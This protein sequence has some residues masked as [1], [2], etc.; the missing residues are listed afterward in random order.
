MGHL[1]FQGVLFAAL[2]A[3]VAQATDF[4]DWL[5]RR[6]WRAWDGTRVAD[7]TG[8]TFTAW[9]ASPSELRAELAAAVLAKALGVPSAP[10]FPALGSFVGKTLVP[11]DATIPLG[12]VVPMLVRPEVAASAIDRDSLSS[13]RLAELAVGLL[14]RYVVAPRG[15][16]TLTGPSPTFVEANG[17]VIPAR[18]VDAFLGD[19]RPPAEI[20]ATVFVAFPRAAFPSDWHGR[21]RIFRAL[22][23][24]LSRLEKLDAAAWEAIAGRAF[25][26]LGDDSRRC[27]AVGARVRAARSQLHAFFAKSAPLEATSLL[28][29]SSVDVPIVRLPPSLENL[30]AETPALDVLW[31]VWLDRKAP[32]GGK[33][34]ANVQIESDKDMSRIYGVLPH[35][36]PLFLDRKADRVPQVTL[37][38]GNADTLVV[39]PL[40]DP[41]AELIAA[42][43][44]E[45]GARVLALPKHE[46]PHGSKLGEKLKAQILDEYARRPF[47]RVGVVELP[48]RPAE[49]ETSLARDRRFLFRYFDHHEYKT[50]RL[51]RHL[52]EG[53][54]EQVADFLGFEL[55]PTDTA[56][57][58]YDRS[59]VF[60]VLEV[61]FTPASLKPIAGEVP[62]ELE[63]LGAGVPST[64]GPLYF[65]DAFGGKIGDA[66]SAVA[67][68]DAPNVPNI[69]IVEPHQIRFS[70]HPKLEARLTAAFGNLQQAGTEHYAFGDLARSRGWGYKN[71]SPE[72]RPVAFATLAAVIREVAGP[73]GEIA[74]AAVLGQPMDVRAMRLDDRLRIGDGPRRAAAIRAL[75][76]RKLGDA[77]RRRLLAVA[78]AAVGQDIDPE[79]LQALFGA[80]TV[81][82]YTS[83][84]FAAFFDVAEASQDPAWRPFFAAAQRAWMQRYRPW[85]K[86]LG[87]RAEKALAAVP[88]PPSLPGSA[89][90]V[91]EVSDP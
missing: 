91:K 35:R 75:D 55:S 16:T 90:C 70:G 26:S 18:I 87:P 25:E 40:N 1:G 30:T 69:V 88:P 13:E 43:A 77:D 78:E 79:P 48:G 51:D 5:G 54:A 3:L 84:D 89:A 23:T 52:A 64:V 58:L 53:S 45:A 85:H 27:D 21:D 61:G 32:P 44:E 71:I 42:M 14:H 81:P 74:L 59:F 38:E 19:D 4:T 41:E 17:H 82:V 11:V 73:E 7:A 20:F 83:Y 15:P 46:Y 65:L 12:A 2:F 47:T 8:R 60:G 22:E 62:P 86:V 66:A 67:V 63:R 37:W 31:N 29:P 9:T 28:K 33:T 6:E 49:V 68:R 39:V 10:V 36:S 72:A 57:A 76:W 80:V 24:T 56:I 50:D 34:L